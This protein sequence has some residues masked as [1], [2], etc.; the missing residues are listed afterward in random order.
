MTTLRRP[1]RARPTL[2][3]ALAAA[4]I[5]AGL[6]APAQAQ[7]AKAEW[8][9]LVEAANA[10][11][12]VIMNSQ[13]NKNARDF[14][15]TEWAKAFPK[16]KLSISVVP[17]SQFLARMRTERAAGKFLWDIGF[18]GAGT[19]YLLMREGIV[20]PLKPEF[21]LDDVKNPA[22]WGGW[23]RVFF[24]TKRQHVF[25]VTEFLKSPAFNA[26]KV[27]PAKVQAH[28][29]KVLLD[30]EYRGK[31]VWHDPTTPGSG[32][33]A[34]FTLRTRFGDD[35]LRKLV[36]DQKINIVAGQHEVIEHMA[37]GTSWIGIGPLIPGLLDEYLKA[38]VKVDV[39]T[40]GNSPEVNE[41]SIGGSALYVFNKRPN[42]NATK[43][44]VNWLFSKDVQ[45]GFA[46]ALNQDSRRR[47]LP[48]VLTADITP[49]RGATYIEPQRE[50]HEAAVTASSRFVKEILQSTR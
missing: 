46:K 41:L 50:E 10:E 6:H 34:A 1:I 8:A 40:F 44:F 13:P 28:G 23:D 39:R 19:G 17:A 9:K 36:V 11:G 3:G 37:R 35:G 29:L 25:A 21:V 7:D 24:D 2:A 22:T 30:P 4:T 14:L 47:D 45:H 31:I 5:L 20:D 48:S 42:P 27:P 33:S 15:Q 43:L 12:A 26:E 32:Q 18:A 49:V 38:G 16:I